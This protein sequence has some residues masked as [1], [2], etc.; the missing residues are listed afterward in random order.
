MIPAELTEAGWRECFR[1]GE[2]VL[3]THDDFP[4]GEFDPTW[5]LAYVR[6]QRMVAL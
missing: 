1:H 4:R 2:Y 5:A 6:A 3:V